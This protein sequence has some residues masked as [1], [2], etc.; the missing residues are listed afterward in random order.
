MDEQL[1][2]SRRGMLVCTTIPP[3]AG[4]PEQPFRMIDALGKTAICRVIDRSIL[5]FK[6]V[7]ENRSIHFR[8]C[9]GA[10]AKGIFHCGRHAGGP[11]GA[12]IGIRP[13]VAAE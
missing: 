3:G 1:W 6:V 12:A 8:F 13:V 4:A 5:L 9:E 7:A 11:V 2:R 10:G